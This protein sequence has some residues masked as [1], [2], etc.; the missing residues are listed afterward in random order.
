MIVIL[1]MACGNVAALM[2]GQVDARATEM[3]LRAAL[4]ANR[5]RQLQQLIIEA[6]LVGALAGATGAALATAGFELLVPSLPLGGLADNARLDWTVF[7]AAMLAALA[8]AAIVAIVPGIALWRGSS[9]RATMATTRTGGV[10]ARRPPRRGARRRADRARRPA[11]RRRRAPHPQRDQPPRDRSRRRTDG[12]AIV[13][14]VMPL[15]AT[16]PQR[17]RIVLDMLPVYRRCRA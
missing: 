6:L 5:Q 17:K 16:Q 10:S 3:A 9:L 1:V 7:W 13:D 2:L 8:A 12:V 14:A 4:G 15:G 11:G